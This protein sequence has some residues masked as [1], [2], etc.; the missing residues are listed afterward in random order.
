MAKKTSKKQ[1]VTLV[2]DVVEQAVA[3]IAEAKQNAEAEPK[4]RKMV[5]FKVLASIMEFATEKAQL[6]S[7]HT[8][9]GVEVKFWLSKSLSHFVAD[10]D[11]PDC[12]CKSSAM[13]SSLEHCQGAAEHGRSQKM[14]CRVPAWLYYKAGLNNYFPITRWSQAVI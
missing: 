9:A 3:Q 14:I 4:K 5:E 1:E 11:E 10:G 7:F 2:Q 13:S 6:L 12:S 8:E